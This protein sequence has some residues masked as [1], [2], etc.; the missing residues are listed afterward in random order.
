MGTGGWYRRETRLPQTRVLGRAC[1]ALVLVCGGLAPALGAEVRIVS[2]APGAE[3]VGLVEIK[4]TVSPQPGEKLDQVVV[5]TSRGDSVRMARQ[6]GDTYAASLDTT[7]LRN[8]RQALLVIC[9][10]KGADARLNY[11]DEAW[12]S[13]IRNWMAEVAVT[14][15]NPYR[16]FWGDLHAHTSYSDGAGVPKE[17]YEHAREKAKL[18]FFAVTDHSQL[19][20]F[21]E[22]QDV[23]AQAEAAYQPGRYATLWGLEATE[24]TGH[25]CFYMSPTPRL[26]SNLDLL[27]RAASDMALL[28]HFNHPNVKPVEGQPWRDDFQGFH[29]FPMA[30]RAIAMVEVRSVEE[31]AAYIKLLD[32]G[33]HVGAAG[34]QDAHDRA[35]GAGKSWTVALARELTREAM[36]DALW[37]RR[38]YSS[39]DRNLQLT[40]TLDGEDMGAQIARPAGELVSVV[41]AVDPDAEQVIEQVDWFVDGQIARTVRAGRPEF[42]GSEP[43]SFPPG[44]HYCF[45]RV[46]QMDGR[47]TWSSPIWVTAYG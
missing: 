22:Y 13:A 14:V 18:D 28:G 30:D 25:L 24:G 10:A 20:T 6:F 47:M 21:E 7:R 26:P 8:G 37:S 23:I 4:A 5:Q 1:A 41:V 39:A 29:H 46:T 17:A 42:A 11:S 3:L 12:A 35:W 44:R 19:L 36:L 16:F 43:L 27:Y 31:E 15:A 34:C 40:F 9:S 45:V 38:T 2:P 33:W 32:A